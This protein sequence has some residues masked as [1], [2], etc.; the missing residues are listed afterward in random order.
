MQAASQQEALSGGGGGNFTPD[1]VD[2]INM[3]I[4]A[5]SN[6]WIL[7]QQQIT[8]INEAITLGVSISN[9]NS[10]PYVWFYAILDNDLG[11]TGPL[12]AAQI[13]AIQAVGVYIPG[14]SISISV[15]PNKYICFPVFNDGAKTVTGTITVIN[16]SDNNVQLDTMT[17]IASEN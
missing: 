6:Y 11:I 3:N 2:W 12:T 16:E 5:G 13:Q 7:N 4:A 8:G 17:F 10:Q 1:P 15:D 14:S 9:T